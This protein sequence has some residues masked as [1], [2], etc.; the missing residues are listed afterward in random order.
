MQVPNLW[1]QTGLPRP[2]A[3][4]AAS[5][6]LGTLGQHPLRRMA[7]TQLVSA[8]GARTPGGASHTASGSPDTG[9]IVRDL[10]P[11]ARLEGA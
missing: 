4:L 6:W 3:S 10:L 2:R 5:R 8:A 7:W 11:E 9:T 1:W